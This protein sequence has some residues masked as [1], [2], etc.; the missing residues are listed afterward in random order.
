MPFWQKANLKKVLCW[1]AWST[2]STE[3]WTEN[4]PGRGRAADLQRQCGWIVTPTWTPLCT[5]VCK[6]SCN[7]AGGRTCGSPGCIYFFNNFYQHKK[8]HTVSSEAA[9]TSINT[10]SCRIVTGKQSIP[11]N[12]SRLRLLTFSSTRSGQ[13]SGE[14][15]DSRVA[16][17]PH[18]LLHVCPS[19][20]LR[21]TGI[22]WGKR[23]HR[24]T[25]VYPESG[26]TMLDIRHVGGRAEACI[27]E[28]TCRRSFEKAAAQWIKEI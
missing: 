11:K 10:V 15:D 21:P 18:S 3:H 14:R 22:V 28:K 25:V 20:P 13:V 24:G 6:P 19:P 2:A 7:L 4:Q 16:W 8:N 5:G 12:P 9:K 17:V 26:A 1:P 27:S 23:I